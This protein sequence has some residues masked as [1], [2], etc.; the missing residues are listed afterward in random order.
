MEAT[1]PGNQLA[2]DQLREIVSS[3]NAIAFVGAGASADLYPTWPQLI[4][5]LIA[6]CMNR[7]L[8]MPPDQSL[9]RS[10]AKS[11]P[12]E[13]VDLIRRRLG[14]QLYRASLRTIFSLRS[15]SNERYYTTAQLALSQ[16]PF[17]GVV[18]TNYDHGILE[19]RAASEHVTR[20]PRFSTWQDNDS[21]SQWLSGD[22][23]DSADPPFLFL[24]GSYQRSET[25]VLGQSDYL[26]AYR[27][28]LFR[29]AFERLWTAEH[30]VFVGI[31]FSDPWL[32]FI[33]AECASLFTNSASQPRHY[34]I[35]GVDAEQPYTPDM[36]LAYTH[37]Y[38]LTP[39]FY[40]VHQQSESRDHSGMLQILHHLRTDRSSGLTHAP[41]GPA[42]DHDG[43]ISLAARARWETQ[44]EIR[45]SALKKYIPSLYVNRSLEAIVDSFLLHD[46]A[47]LNMCIDR[48]EN[49]NA[50]KIVA[51][52]T[53]DTQLK[54]RKS[55]GS[56][57]LSA[58]DR[59]R[60]I[61]WRESLEG[62]H[63]EVELLFDE[64]AIAG[65]LCDPI[66]R[67]TFATLADKLN[68]YEQLMAG[69]NKTLSDSVRAAVC[70]A[71]DLAKHW[72]SNVCVIVDRAG[73]GKTNLSCHL[74]QGRS[75]IEPALFVAGRSPIERPRDILTAVL[76]KLGYAGLRID[77]DIA[78][79]KKLLEQGGASVTVFIDGVNESR[80]IKLL[81]EALEIALERLGSVR[82]RFVITCRDIYWTFFE[83]AEWTKRISLLVRN[84]LYEFSSKEQLDALPK[85]LKHFN[86]EVALGD[87]AMKRCRHPLLLRFFCEAYGNVGGATVQLGR[88]NEIR[89]KPL[90]DDYWVG[91]VESL[92]IG[93]AGSADSPEECIYS[94]AAH[95][96]AVSTASIST[97]HFS[98]I[99]SVRDMRSQQSLFVRL[100]DEDIIIGEEP[101][102]DVSERMIVFVYEEFMEYSIARMLFTRHEPSVYNARS[103]FFKLHKQSKTFVNALGVCEYLCAFYLDSDLPFAAVEMIVEMSRQ[104][105][106]WD[107]IVSNLFAKY[108]DSIASILVVDKEYLQ[109]NIVGL[110]T[111]L[112][113]LDRLLMIEVCTALLFRIAFPSIISLETIRHERVPPLPN[114][115]KQ[116]LFEVDLGLGREILAII[117]KNLRKSNISPA[118]DATWKLAAVK[119]KNEWPGIIPEMI[120]ALWSLLVTSPRK[121]LLLTYA[122]N[123]LFSSA[124]AVRRAV[125][126]ITKDH[127]S[128]IVTNLTKEVLAFEK[129]PDVRD[130]LA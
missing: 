98:Q 95:M 107:R 18:T 108:E 9:W 6:D 36:R 17:K 105:G 1:I 5:H 92:R 62:I 127:K 70:D 116:C 97:S 104:G 63:A 111:I 74:A 83:G 19:A 126:L 114:H 81:N 85:Y 122:C 24:H 82:V 39:I 21:L 34:A 88:R 11:E 29:T 106:A 115:S 14:D 119:S 128:S 78:H 64:L 40:R 96:L 66:H 69:D 109:R 4:D 2:F 41:K 43:A 84:R 8:G 26:K 45:R 68:E 125:A 102:T 94:L 112:S 87:D 79:L 89:L 10:M 121:P 15:D 33:A 42:L 22:I 44:E 54:S 118:R 16:L 7:G 46:D 57:S 73:G 93:S 129:D 110:D 37:S 99:T 113:A 49:L 51:T 91:K 30:L 123:G 100:L 75:Q 50:S 90:F 12:L 38:S 23:F 86:I 58:E 27:T 60:L 61:K 20:I 56:S 80:D 35:V 120:K 28:P 3:R 72:A 52:T 47:L 76:T 130:L 55:R 124:P 48:R 25:I 53:L 32:K 67:T 71:R 117:A 31:G 101:T 103:L 77:S 59:A 13:T 65:K